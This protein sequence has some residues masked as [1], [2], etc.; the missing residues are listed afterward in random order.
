MY[1]YVVLR[2]GTDDAQ[3][4]IDDAP[5]N[6]VTQ[7]RF[8]FFVAQGHTTTMTHTKGLFERDIRE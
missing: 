6:T 2:I 4:P 1:S 5:F 3:F 8:A 7:T